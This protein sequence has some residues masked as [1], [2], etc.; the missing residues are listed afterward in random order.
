MK[1]RTTHD[2]L[3]PPGVT[4]FLTT[5]ALLFVLGCGDTPTEANGDG[6]SSTVAVTHRGTFHA[7]AHRGTGVAEIVV[8]PDG[9]R[10]LRFT[11]F[12]TDAGPSLEVYLVAATDV[13]DSRTVL[14]AGYVTLGA[15]SSPS[16]NQ[17]YPVPS[18][19]NLGVYRSVSIWCVPF[20][21]NFTTASL[22]PV[23]GT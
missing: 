12:Q 20:S 23:A 3:G 5:L 10:S 8:A 11:N 18:N 21:V 7:V 16:G 22:T 2:R 14:D 1:L 15:L 9:S 19:V 17:S 4:Y 13:F 6:Q